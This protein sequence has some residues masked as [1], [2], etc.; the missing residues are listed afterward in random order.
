MKIARIVDQE[1]GSF[2][3]EYDNMLGKK[4]FMRLD[5]DTYERALREA[6]TFLE[7]SVEGS[8]SDGNQWDLE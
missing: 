4:N 1:G 3:L 5:A 2:A 7:I 6:K 8:D